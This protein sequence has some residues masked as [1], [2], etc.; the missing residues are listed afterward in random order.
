MI[1][2]FSLNPGAKL[3]YNTTENAFYGNRLKFTQSLQHCKL[4]QAKGYFLAHSS[5]ILSQ[6]HLMQGHPLTL[7]TFVNVYKSDT[8]PYFSLI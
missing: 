1:F 6:I 7:T 5:L 4:D 8:M 3:E 2:M